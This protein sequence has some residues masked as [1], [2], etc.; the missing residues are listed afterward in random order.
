M[1]SE[2][3]SAPRPHDGSRQAPHKWRLDTKQ[4]VRR[5]ID[6]RPIELDDVKYAWAAYKQG[7]LK[8]MGF[9]D[10]MSPEAF[11]V[12]FSDAILN[13]CHAAWTIFGHT[14]KG[15]IPVG[16]LLAVWGPGQTFLTVLGIAWMPWAS[17]RNIVECTVGFFEGTRKEFS[18]MGY[19]THEH[20][21]VYDVCRELGIMRRVGTSYTVI[22]GTALAVFETRKE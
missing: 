3:G 14:K 4:T 18:F 16:L 21:K 10:G 5:A 11:K 22:P 1:K 17:K 8:E 2:S 13:N 6:Y 19:A 7:A 20:K 12:G 9:Q 15:F